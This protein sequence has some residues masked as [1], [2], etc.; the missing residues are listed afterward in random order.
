MPNKKRKPKRPTVPGPT[1]PAG[2]PGAVTSDRPT[3][4]AAPGIAT[5]D[6]PKVAVPP[7]EPGGPNRPARKEEARRQREALRRRQARRRYYRIG[8]IALAVVVLAAGLGLFAI[9]VRNDNKRKIAAETS[10]A[11]CGDVRTIPPYATVADDRAH[12]GTQGPNGTVSTAPPL[13]TYRTQ[14][15]TSGPHDQNPL[16]AGVYST[17]PDVYRTIHSLEHGAVIIWYSPTAPRAAVA[18]ITSFYSA[19]S[20]NDHVIVAPYNY[21]SQGTAGQL[22]K[23]DQMVMVAWHRMEQC[24]GVSLSVARRFVSLYRTPT[25]VPNPSGY[26]GE[27]PEAGVGI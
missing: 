14:P 12:I 10:S 11:H 23:S 7:A 16:T 18:Q 9:K 3:R 25:G 26:K 13:S 5:R 19:A 17:P 24:G 4:A 1:R 22:P 8:V 27:A 20:N 15:P 2:V 6:A 21:P